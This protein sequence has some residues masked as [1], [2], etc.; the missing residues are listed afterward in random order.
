[1]TA[2]SARSEAASLDLATLPGVPSYQRTGFCGVCVLPIEAEQPGGLNQRHV[3]SLL[4]LCRNDR[5]IL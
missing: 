2:T 1:M 4:P 3:G 5:L